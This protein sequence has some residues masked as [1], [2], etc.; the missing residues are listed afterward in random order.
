MAFLAA[1]LHIS[2]CAENIRE[3]PANIITNYTEHL[4]APDDK[5]F[6]WF[7]PELHNSHYRP[8][9]FG[10]DTLDYRL[11]APEHADGNNVSLLFKVSYGGDVRHYD[12][13]KDAEGTSHTIKQLKHHAVR[14]QLF[15]SLISSCLY[16]GQYSLTLSRSDLEQISKAGLQLQSINGSQLYEHIDLPKDY[17]QGFLN[18]IHSN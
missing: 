12:I 14:C 7:A 4:A 15:N 13:T 11:A 5:G 18:A 1:T 8:L 2:G 6:A 3:A 10:Y 17:V 16:E 9:F